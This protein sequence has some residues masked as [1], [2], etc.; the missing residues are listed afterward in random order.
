LRR[1]ALASGVANRPGELGKQ[2]GRLVSAGVNPD[3]TYPAVEPT[4][5][6]LTSDDPADA[7]RALGLH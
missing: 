2:L 1:E 7:K 4:K 3:S 5:V 6:I